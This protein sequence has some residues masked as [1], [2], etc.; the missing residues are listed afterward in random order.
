[1]TDK[2]AAPQ[3]TLSVVDTVALIVGIVIGAGIFKTPSLVA[4]NTGSDAAFLLTWL[5]GGA[6][7]LIGAL[8]YAELA[9]AYPHAGG[10]YHYLTRAFGRNVAFLFAWARMMV[11]QTGSIATV[12]FVFG[13]YVA[14]LAPLGKHAPSVYAALAVVLT[15]ALNV[16]GVQQGKWT[17]NALTAAK[18][19]GLLSV[20]VAGLVF[21]T[22]PPQQAGSDAPPLPPQSP[23]LGLAMIFVLY[24]YGGWNEAAYVS[25]ELRDVRRNMTRALLWGI[26]IITAIYLLVN[27]AYLK[28]LGLTGMSQSPAVAA[29]L[30]R[31]VVGAGGAKFVSLLVAIA[32]LGGVNATV[33]TGART[34]YA[35]GRDFA[36]FGFLGRWHERAHTPTRALLTQGVI[37]LALVLLGAFTRKGFS[38]M[39][40]YITPVFW[41]FFLLAG[42]SLF[43]LRTKE[44]EVARPF[45]VPLYP[46]VPLLFCMTCVYMLQS[47]LAYTGIGALVGVAVLMGGIPLLLWARRR[48][49]MKSEVKV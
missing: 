10:D 12:A 1:M 21:A 11:I 35:L 2:A 18:V 43:V 16:A 41:F 3:P 14:E 13:D 22:A 31:R 32:A 7:A 45:R 6:M 24:A 33:F 20:V 47:S 8:C 9:T 29:D 30:M 15:T 44:P 26:G 38:T 4:A 37:A 34:N 5:A 48:E 27:L 40:D 46:L 39:V 23:L 25:A 36:L 42:L 17:Q 28:G 19:V 49:D